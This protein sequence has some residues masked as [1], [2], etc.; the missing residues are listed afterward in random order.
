MTG[1]SPTMETCLTEQYLKGIFRHVRIIPCE[2]E[3]NSILLA[4]DRE[5]K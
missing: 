3:G 4:S 1:G 5:L 2:N